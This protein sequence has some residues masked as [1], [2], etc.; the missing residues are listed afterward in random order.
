M[1]VVGK[2]YALN[3]CFCSSSLTATLEALDGDNLREL[4]KTIAIQERFLLAFN[5]LLLQLPKCAPLAIMK[6][7]PAVNSDMLQSILLHRN[8]SLF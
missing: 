7:E 6:M 2:N 3:H 4:C 8:H 1:R 5:L